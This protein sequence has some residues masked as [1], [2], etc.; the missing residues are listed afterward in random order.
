MFSRKIAEEE[1]TSTST[2]T[3][4]STST[5][6]SSDGDFLREIVKEIQKSDANIVSA[7]VHDAD[8]NG[9]AVGF[10][11]FFKKDKKKNKKVA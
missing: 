4:T 10:A 6:G 11:S 9:H 7:V 2:P 3:P 5:F 8:A 1:P